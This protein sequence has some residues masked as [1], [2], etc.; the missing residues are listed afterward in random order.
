MLLSMGVLWSLISG[1]VVLKSSG[2]SISM[3]RTGGGPGSSI[4]GRGVKRNFSMALFLL[5]DVARSSSICVCCFVGDNVLSSRVHLCLKA[6][7]GSL[8]SV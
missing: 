1:V 2:M 5:S 7:Y 8:Y 6:Q 3:A 4:V